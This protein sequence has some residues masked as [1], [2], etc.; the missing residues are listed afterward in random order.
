[1][2]LINGSKGLIEGED[3]LSLTINTGANTITNAGDI[4][5]VTNLTIASPVKNTGELYA[6]GGTLAAQGAVSGAGSVYVAAGAAVDFSGTGDVFTG[7]LSGAGTVG[8][9]GGTDAIDAGATVTVAH[10]AECGAATDVAVNANL[11]YAGQWSQTAGTL[12][13]ASGDLA[14]FTGTGDVFSGTLAGTGGV[15]FTAGSDTLTGTTLSASSVVISGATVTLGG[16]ITLGD[17]VT[18]TTPHLIVAAGG[19]TLSGSGRLNLTDIAT[20][21]MVGAN[22]AATLTNNVLIVGAGQ[23]GDGTMTLVNGAKG[24][25]E[26]EDTLPLTIDTGANTIANAGDI[27]AVTT[28]TIASPVNNTGELYAT[29]GTLAAEGAVTGAG[30]VYVAAGAAVDFSGTGN[31]FTG[32]LSGAGTVG[33]TG[34]TDAFD[35][36]ATVTVAHVAQSGAA[37]DVAANANLHY[38]GQWSQ[39]AGTLSVASGDLATFTGTGDVFS[40]TLA[41]TGGVDFTAGSDTLT[42]TTLSASSVLISGATVTLGGAITLSDTV[43]VT[44]PHLTV[45]AGGATLSGTGRLNLTDTASNAIIGANAAATLTNDVLIVGAGQIGD[46][47]MTLVNGSKGVIEGEDTLL[48]TLNTGANTIDNAGAI[49]AVTKLTITGA[50][51]NT[52]ELFTSGGTLTVTGTVTGGGT[53]RIAGGVAD[54]EAGLTG[55]VD[56]ASSTGRLDLGSSKTYSGNVIG[57]STSGT[58]SLDLLDIAFAGTTTGVYTGTTTSGV[59]TVTEGANVATIH[60]VG[61]YIGQTFNLS[62]GPDGGTQVVDPTAPKTAAADPAMLTP[63]APSPALFVQAAASFEPSGRP[64]ELVA[65]SHAPPALTPMLA[66]AA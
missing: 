9:T 16:T 42:G 56:F 65:L 59:L 55:A 11:H 10:I 7:P 53:V 44:T 34:G 33:F 25:I 54:L 8:F 46:G 58:N 12:S 63:A 21:A 61:D 64:G 18:V 52:G 27:G 31:V 43:T 32:P 2:T 47:T 66:H 50:V 26:G 39:T 40:G 3:S 37:T 17:I 6:T 13:V 24:L 51:D 5:A 45:A 48:L 41:G 36:G 14:T 30:K 57:L 23:I 62:T 19:A 29:G 4:G 28:L 22:S 60:L 38:A 15:A 1:M 49:G 20:N 35:A